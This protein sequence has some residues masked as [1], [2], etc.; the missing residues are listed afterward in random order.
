MP[1]ARTIDLPSSQSLSPG[2]AKRSGTTA[3]AILLAAVIA[4]LLA[5]LGCAYF[6]ARNTDGY[7]DPTQQWTD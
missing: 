7:P 3:R 2:S 5:L 6:G 1:V 4:F